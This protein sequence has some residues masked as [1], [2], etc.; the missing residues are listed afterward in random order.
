VQPNYTFKASYITH[1]SLRPGQCGYHQVDSLSQLA[2]NTQD[3][4]TELHDAAF[5]LLLSLIDIPVN[6]P[7]TQGATAL[8]MASQNGHDAVVK[9]LLSHSDIDIN[10]R[11]SC[12]TAINTRTEHA[13]GRTALSLASKNGHEA[14]VK[15]LLSRSSDTVNTD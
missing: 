5:S 7:S 3:G 4:W 9:L 8:I 1:S 15:L 2:F 14:V 12:Q 6:T 10:T 13:S 11:R